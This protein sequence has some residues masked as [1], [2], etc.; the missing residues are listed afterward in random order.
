M[1]ATSR[2]SRP[3]MAASRHAACRF[4][5]YKRLGIARSSRIAADAANTDEESLTDCVGKS[6]R[7]ARGHPKGRVSREVK[8][9]LESCDTLVPTRSFPLVPRSDLAYCLLPEL[10]RVSG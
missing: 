3:R 4:E 8:H 2:V 10:P 7:G 1:A 5:A 6:I 9:V